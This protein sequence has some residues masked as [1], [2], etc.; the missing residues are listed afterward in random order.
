MAGIDGIQAGL[1]YIVADSI[2]DGAGEIK[3]FYQNGKERA[4]TEAFRQILHGFIVHIKLQIIIIGF[5]D[6]F[7]KI[8]LVKLYHHTNQFKA[9]Q[10][11]FILIHLPGFLRIDMNDG[12]AVFVKLF[13]KNALFQF[14]DAVPECPF[15]AVNVIAPDILIFQAF[16]HTVIVGD[17]NIQP[18][19]HILL[20]IEIL[21]TQLL[22]FDFLNRLQAAP[23]FFI[24][25]SGLC[26]FLFAYQ[27][28]QCFLIVKE[29]HS[30]T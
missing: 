28:L 14:L 24:G 27:I 12:R 29:I 26:K 4:Y 3:S 7:I 18:A 15:T 20:F 10:L 16:Q 11:I 25:I 30:H 22:Q 5:E 13:N 1:V 8:A 19:F 9:E 21:N 17:D 6:C 23:A 2:S